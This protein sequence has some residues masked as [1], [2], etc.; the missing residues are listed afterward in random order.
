MSAL[1]LHF[2]V[3]SCARFPSPSPSAVG[4]S[5]FQKQPFPHPTPCAAL[6]GAPPARCAW[7]LAFLHGLPV[8]FVALLEG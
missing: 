2:C 8:E 1:V 5:W 7:C 3:C 4:L 6:P